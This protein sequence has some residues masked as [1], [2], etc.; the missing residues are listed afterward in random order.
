MHDDHFKNNH[1]TSR[2][3]RNIRCRGRCG[4]FWQ[5]N[6]N[7]FCSCRAG[8]TADYSYQ[9]TGS[10][11][12]EDSRYDLPAGTYSATVTDENGCTNTISQTIIQPNSALAVSATTV[13]PIC[14]N[15]NGSISATA[16]GGTGA[17]FYDWGNGITGPNRTGL[18]AGTYTVTVYDANACSSILTKT[19]TDSGSSLAVSASSTNVT[20]FGNANGAD[21]F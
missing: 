17:Y 1:R 2:T 3:A 15:A 11:S 7:G 18:A 19:L 12:T 5:R 16:T 13:N 10:T 21:Q 9:W 20:C 14:N 8:G 4:L 6:W